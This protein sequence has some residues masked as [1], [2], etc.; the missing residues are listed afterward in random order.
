MG[1]IL[2]TLKRFMVKVATY[3][4]VQNVQLS[5][6]ILM[7]SLGKQKNPE[8]YIAQKNKHFNKVLH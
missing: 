7:Q 4:G 1:S 6:Y 5:L 3:L 8:P 2:L